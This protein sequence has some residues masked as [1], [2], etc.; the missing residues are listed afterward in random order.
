MG[1]GFYFFP[2][3][4]LETDNFFLPFALLCAIIFFPPGVD[5]LDLNPCLFLRFLLEG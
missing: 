5:I 1:F 3:R 4:S 2:V